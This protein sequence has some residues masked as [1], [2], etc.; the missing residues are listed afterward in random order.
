[1]PEALQL[2][3]NDHPPFPEVCAGHARA[4]AALGYRVRTVFFE[5]RGFAPTPCPGFEFAYSGPDALPEVLA[6]RRPDVLVSHRYRAYQAGVRLARRLPVSPHIVVAHEFGM[7]ARRSRRLR[8]RLTDRT[9][10]LFAGVSEPVVEDLERSGV[11]SPIVLPN[12]ID[13]EALRQA[14]KPRREARSALGLA[15][16]AFVIAVVGRLHPKKDPLRALRAFARYRLEDDNAC[17]VFLGEGE[18]REELQATAGDGVVFAGFRADV[19][20]LLG[21]FDIVLSCSTEREAFGLALLEAMVAGVPI[22]AADRAGPRSVLGDCGVYFDTD[23]ELI[24]GLRA[25]RNNAGA[26]AGDRSIGRAAEMFSIEA[27]AR[28]YRRILLG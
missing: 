22:V 10:P 8:R 20:H 5:D 6:G 11:D 3:P 1:M 7:F 27:L 19:R 14:M 23:A 2:C 4:L 13:G 26:H 16:S 28:R 25:V 24:A 12:P 15:E 9:H 17:L 18:L 21:A